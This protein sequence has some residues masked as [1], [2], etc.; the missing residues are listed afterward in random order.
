MFSNEEEKQ[1]VLEVQSGNNEKALKILILKYENLLR[2]VVWTYIKKYPYSPFEFFD[3][4]NYSIYIFENLTKKYKLDSE[5]SFP[6]YIQLFLKYYLSNYVKSF[7][8]KNNTMMNNFQFPEDNNFLY[9]AEEEDYSIDDIEKIIN[10]LNF[11]TYMEK[12]ITILTVCDELSP[13]TIAEKMDKNITSVYACMA[14]VK[15]KMNKYYIKKG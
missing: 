2:S 1:L 6:K 11:L 7:F 9:K 15:N 8:T 14:R 10:S 4:Y 5:K 12:T 3:L 13:S